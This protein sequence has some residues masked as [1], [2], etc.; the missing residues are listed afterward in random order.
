M[1]NV[2][3]Q[4]QMILILILRTDKQSSRKDELQKTETD[5]ERLARDFATYMTYRPKT[6]IGSPQPVCSASLMPCCTIGSIPA[7]PVVNTGE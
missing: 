3:K 6:R 5:R 7:G 2:H 1:L 4:H